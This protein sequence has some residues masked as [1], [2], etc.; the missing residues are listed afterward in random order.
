MRT[1]V[2]IETT[3]EQFKDEIYRQKWQWCGVIGK[4]RKGSL[5]SFQIQLKA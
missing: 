3:Q 4:M 1:E 5:G 2:K